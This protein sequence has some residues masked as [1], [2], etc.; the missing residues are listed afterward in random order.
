MDQLHKWP[1]SRWSALARRDCAIISHGLIPLHASVLRT[2][3]DIYFYAMYVRKLHKSALVL[4][5]LIGALLSLK[6]FFFGS[7]QVRQESG[8]GTSGVPL[9]F[10]HLKVVTI[11]AFDRFQYF[12]QCMEALR[13]AWGSDEYTVIVNIDG[14]PVNPEAYDGGGWHDV[15]AY[16][17]QL[18]ILAQAGVGF[19]EVIVSIADAPIGLH[20]NKRRAVEAAFNLSDFVIVLEDDI[21]LD[22]DA[23]RWFEWHITSG[24]IFQRPEVALATCFA[25]TFPYSS[26]SLVEAHDLLAVHNLGLLDKF[27]LLKW[28]TPWGWASWR[29][30]WEAVGGNWTGRDMDLKDAIVQRNWFETQ[31]MVARCNNVGVVGLHTRGAAGEPVHQRMVT[32]S[33]FPNTQLCQYSELQQRMNSTVRSLIR[34]GYKEVK[35]NVRLR[36]TVDMFK[37]W[38]LEDSNSRFWTSTC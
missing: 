4:T 36:E 8:K 31:P 13:R 6:L 20:R 19:K 7:V 29:R 11:V 17:H 24:Y 9:S 15:V 23:L 22:A 32:S 2:T 28:H 16:S 35:I 1:L 34:M 33:S 18:Q 14:C 27:K 38:K 37:T 30:T 10:N 3:I 12:R 25:S 21:V 26:D 5:I